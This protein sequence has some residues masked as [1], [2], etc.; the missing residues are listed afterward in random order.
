[1]ITQK[2]SIYWGILP[3][4]KHPDF[5][6]ENRKIPWIFFHQKPCFAGGR[7]GLAILVQDAE[8]GKLAVMK[9][10]DV[11]W[12]AAIFRG[13]VAWFFEINGGGIPS[14]S[15]DMFISGFWMIDGMNI[16]GFR[17]TF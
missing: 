4:K 3:R 11:P 8:T 12:T 17:T 1:M 5:S 10:M 2:T 14:H 16:H 6:A 15:W 13:D 9:A 7:S